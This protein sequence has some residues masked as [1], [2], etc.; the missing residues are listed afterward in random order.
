MGAA[1]GAGRPGRLRA[2]PARAPAG[3]QAGRGGMGGGDDFGYYLPFNWRGFYDFG[4]SLIGDWGVHILGPANWALGLSPEN[5]VSVEC[6]KKDPLPPTTFPDVFTI[7]FEFKA[8]NGHAAG[9][10]VLVSGT[11]AAMRICR[12]A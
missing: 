10:G 2:P 3:A 8:R 6:I 9:H 7:K 1:R 4:S 12:P 11:R 5:L